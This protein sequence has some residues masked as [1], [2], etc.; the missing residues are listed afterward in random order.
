MWGAALP[1]TAQVSIEGGRQQTNRNQYTW[2]VVNHGSKTITYVEIPHHMGDIFTAPPHWTFEITG[3]INIA[4]TGV[5][6]ARAESPAHAIRPGRS[7]VCSLTVGLYRRSAPR[8]RAVRIG[9]ADGT[10]ETINGVEV[11]W[12]VPWFRRHVL[13]IGFGAMFAVYLLVQ[14][15]RGR[16]RQEPDADRAPASSG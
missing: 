15:L 16:R 7:A 11:P 10:F 14:A 2:K 1:A 8:L 5:V 12:R 4:T 6:R 13:L 3:Q 9:F